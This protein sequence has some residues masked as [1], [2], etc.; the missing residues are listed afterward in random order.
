MVKTILVIDDEVSSID[1]LSFILQREGYNVIS[2]ENGE[3]GVKYLKQ[4][5]NS[6]SLIFL[7]LMMPGMSGAEFLQE[8]KKIPN[9]ANT[10]VILQ[11]GAPESEIEAI[12]S[13]NNLYEVIR[14]PFSRQ[15]IIESVKKILKG[16]DYYQQ[17]PLVSVGA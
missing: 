1:I 4:N 7:D 11:T 8:I 15:S 16:D 6:V 10:P 13:H 9:A 5:L 17:P 2:V 14:K 3:E 12:P